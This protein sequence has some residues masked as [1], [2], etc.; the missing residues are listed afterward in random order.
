VARL[1]WLFDRLHARPL[2]PGEGIGCAGPSVEL[3]FC[4]GRVSGRCGSRTWISL[5]FT[6][7]RARSSSRCARWQTGYRP[8]RELGSNLVL[9]GRTEAT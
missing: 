7:G 6:P 4:Y 5:M 1:R 2:R 9:G 3:C 8:V